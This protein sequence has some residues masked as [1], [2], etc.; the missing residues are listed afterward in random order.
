MN[1]LE[2]MIDRCFGAKDR[3]FAEHPSDLN[4]A[5]EM[6]IEL[7]ERRIVWFEFE[8]ILRRRLARMPKL[9]IDQQVRRARAFIE[10]WL[11]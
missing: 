8:P 9:D 3:P 2:K 7:R 6:L 11:Y 1:D 10:P 5:F 4:D